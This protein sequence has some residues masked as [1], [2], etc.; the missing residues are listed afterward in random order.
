MADEAPRPLDLE[1]LGGPVLKQSTSD[2]RRPVRRRLT[3]IAAIVLVGVLA[4]AI[5]L[6]PRADVRVVP[7]GSPAV[8]NAEEL[9]SAISDALNVLRNAD[10]VEGVERAYTDDQLDH[11]IWFTTRPNGDF[12]LITHTYD[13]AEQ[14]EPGVGVSVGGDT[15]GATE[16]TPWQEIPQVQ[17]LIT[18]IQA[19]VSNADAYE[20]LPFE[21]DSEIT[22]QNTSDGGTLWTSEDEAITHSFLIHPD[23]YLASWTFEFAQPRNEYHTSF[24]RAIIRYV[25]LT[26]PVNIPRPTVGSPLDDTI[27]GLP[28]KLSEAPPLRAPESIRQAEVSSAN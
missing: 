25:P 9:K 13:G 11:Q 4:V 26:D 10:G 19:L 22:W 15:Y 24:D 28:D 20:Y 16:T 7:V 5:L 27:R 21:S 18:P 14:G 6:I 1:E 3:P 17:R 12:A 2:V 8:S 23:G